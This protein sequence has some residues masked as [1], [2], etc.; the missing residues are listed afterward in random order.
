PRWRPPAQVT[1]V[2]PKNELGLADGQAES[3]G[4]P[5]ELAAQVRAQLPRRRLAH[6]SEGN[7][8]LGLPT[9]REVA[10]RQVRASVRQCA[11]VPGGRGRS[12]AV[13]VRAVQRADARKPA[14]G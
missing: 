4:D 14:L 8:L 11:P 5:L 9:L 10:A 1:V 6:A 12:R 13:V 7:T 3:L 2:E